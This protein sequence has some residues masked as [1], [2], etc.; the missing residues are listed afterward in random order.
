MKRGMIQTIANGLPLSNKII[1][2]EMFMERQ[3]V[4]DLPPLQAAVYR[5]LHNNSGDVV[6]YK[7]F[8]S[9]LSPK[10]GRNLL[11]TSIYRLRKAGIRVQ[12]LSGVGYRLKPKRKPVQVFEVTDQTQIYAQ[13]VQDAIHSVMRRHAE[14]VGFES[15]IAIMGVAIGAILHQLP[16]HDRDH[17]I[18]VFVRNMNEANHFS[19]V[20]RLN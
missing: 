5:L 16:K 19:N 1:I 15:Q 3:K 17:Y 11:A 7:Q 4:L 12:N 6:S 20:I 13:D 9:V 18:K 2:E 14:D 8:E 10:K